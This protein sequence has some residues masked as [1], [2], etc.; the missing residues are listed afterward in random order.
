VFKI[1]GAAAAAILA[2]LAFQSS[3]D[4]KP[5]Q[6]GY[7]PPPVP[8]PGWPPVP[9][10]PPG[11][12]SMPVPT[13]PLPAIPGMPTAPK[14]GD[15]PLDA[16][17][18]G[19]ISGMVNGLLK[20]TTVSPEELRQAANLLE[21]N[22]FPLA[23]GCLRARAKEVEIAL[24]LKPSVSGPFRHTIRAGDVPYK[25]AAFFTGDAN[26]WRELG[27]ANPGT[28]GELVTT[29]S[30]TSGAM[31]TNWT[32]WR[33]G[34][35]IIIPASWKP[36]QKMG[37]PAPVAQGS[38]APRPTPPTGGLNDTAHYVASHGDIDTALRDQ[39]TGPSGRLADSLVKP[40]RSLLEATLPPE[41]QY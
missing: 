33:V 8:P 25:L 37:A 24:G 39:P 22:G 29:P 35:S 20:S 26:R 14:P 18:P 11:G 16:T 19:E 15:C 6:P 5:A 23:A 36:Y 32:G 13:A 28:L 7:P 31:T 34:K 9:G 40:F 38:A 17:I 3:S 10:M 2:M 41:D 27:D 12:G 21:M 4:A 30:P 1:I